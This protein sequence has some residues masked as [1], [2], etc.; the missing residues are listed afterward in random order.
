MGAAASLDSSLQARPHG[1]LLT[2]PSSWD[3]GTLCAHL[4]ERG[5]QDLVPMVSARQVTGAQLLTMDDAGLAA[6]GVTGD[7]ARM[8][9]AELRDLRNLF[10][11]VALPPGELAFL[12]AL[13]DATSP[14]A[15]SKKRGWSQ[16]EENQ[17]RNCHG[18]E[19]RDGRVIS[20]RLTHNNMLGALPPDDSAGAGISNLALLR[21]LRLDRNSFPHTIF[22]DL[23]GCTELVIVNLSGCSLGT[24]VQA[25]VPPSIGALRK[26]Q[27]LYLQE[28]NLRGQ[29]PAELCDCTEL[30]K[31]DLS[32]NTLYGP[33]PAALGE[34]LTKLTE[35]RAFGNGFSGRIPSELGN[36]VD[37][38]H[39]DL[40]DNAFKGS[41]PYEALGRCRGL[42][43]L[44][45]HSNYLK[46]TEHATRYF[47]R[48]APE[49]CDNLQ[50]APR[51]FRKPEVSQASE[52]EA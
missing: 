37:L 19:V 1:P 49:L 16:L 20:L 32:F 18:I 3:N 29:L 15:W 43:R 25:N 30:R 26:L 23:G 47:E 42:R 24:A 2:D 40:S 33:L 52:L 45:L 17:G 10:A 31:L 51:V 14:E 41:V 8:L 22:S 7:R 13:R 38:V 36:L 44:L 35:L 28:N 11:P 50:L 12:R 48:H 27:Q 39:L 46:N 34:R 9:S 5:M 21:E 6:L 4:D